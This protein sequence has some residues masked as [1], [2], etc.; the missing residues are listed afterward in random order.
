MNTKILKIAELLSNNDSAVMAE[1]SAC[2]ENTE[3]YYKEYGRK[4]ELLKNLDGNLFSQHKCGLRIKEEDSSCIQWIVLAEC[5]VKNNIAAAL[6]WKC[7][8]EDFSYF[9]KGLAGK[10]KYKLSFR[11][12]WFCEDESIEEWCNILNEKWKSAGGCLAQLDMESDTYIILPLLFTDYEQVK[13]LT[14]DLGQNIYLAGTKKAANAPH[15]LNDF[16]QRYP[17]APQNTYQNEEIDLCM[18]CS[19]NN[20]EK[21]EMFLCMRN[22]NDCFQIMIKPQELS[23]KQIMSVSKYFRINAM[24]IRKRLLAGREIYV[25]SFLYDTMITIKQLE[26]NQ[27]AYEIFPYL[28]KYSKFYECP[29]MLLGP[30]AVIKDYNDYKYFQFDEEREKKWKQE[31]SP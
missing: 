28:P 30:K 26:E 4:Y 20:Q 8:L 17:Y 3:K 2:A 14:W 29:Q 15:I 1:L 22:K 24:Q 10:K 21:D 18:E 12:T 16:F 27:I 25:K 5:L 31:K 19:W 23:A 13:Q 9:V 7:E 6:D 11:K